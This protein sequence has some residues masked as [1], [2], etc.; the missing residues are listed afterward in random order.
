MIHDHFKRAYIRVSPCFALYFISFICIINILYISYFIICL[1]RSSELDTHSTM[2]TLA[3][4]VIG[5]INVIPKD[6]YKGCNSFCIVKFFGAEIFRTELCESTTDPIWQ[7]AETKPMSVFR[8]KEKDHNRSCFLERLDIEVHNIDNNNKASLVSVTKIHLFNTGSP[9]WFSLYDPLEPKQEL[10]SRILVGLTLLEDDGS[11]D[12]RILNFMKLAD[13]LPFIEN[14][15]LYIDFNWA[16]HG[17]IGA[18][19]L[20]AFETGEVV[21]D[22]RDHVHV[23]VAIIFVTV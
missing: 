17:A 12:G 19:L 3:V 11:P 20:P 16:A 1:R 7:H 22:K 5:A 4:Q 8:T 15:H 23:S 6:A 10:R 2:S 9:A 14:H 18:P 13:V 21:M